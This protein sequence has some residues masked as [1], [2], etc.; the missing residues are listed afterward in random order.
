MTTKVLLYSGGMDSEA[1]RLLWEPDSLLYVDM[2]TGYSSAERD[3][4]PD[5]VEVVDLP[6]TTWERP[7]GIIPMRNL[8]LVAIASVYGDQV[9]LAATAG[10]RVL[11]KSPRFA[12]LATDLLGYLWQP[13]HWTD[14]RQ[15]EVVLPVKHLTKRGMIEAVHAEHGA[16][17]VQQL[18]DTF[19]CYEPTNAGVECGACKPCTRKWVA[20][21]AV[22]EAER[23]GGWRHR[24]RIAVGQ[25][26]LPAIA[27]GTYGRAAEADDVLAAYGVRHAENQ[28]QAAQ[29]VL[30][31]RAR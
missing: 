22:G 20:F 7:D 6:L 12:Q 28:Q 18:A 13:Q 16:T 5:D 15:V 31:R 8:L 25:D 19:S 9:G 4:L 3:R 29:A 2:H 24:A 27:A 21:A 17:G 10:D 1:A 11:D 30:N 14:G 23:L 26:V